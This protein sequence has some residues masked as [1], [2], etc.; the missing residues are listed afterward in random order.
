MEI[1]T[2]FPAIA[3]EKLEFGVT[4]S[5]LMYFAILFGGLSKSNTPDQR[6]HHLVSVKYFLGIFLYID[7]NILQPPLPHPLVSREIQ[8]GVVGD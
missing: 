1:K 8:G 6:H 5:N 4:F 3:Y 2:N 7:L